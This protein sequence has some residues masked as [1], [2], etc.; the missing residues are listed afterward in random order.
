M[1]APLFARLKKAPQSRTVRFVRAELDGV[2]ACRQEQAAQFLLRF[3]LPLL[4]RL[5][6][7][8]VP[9]V[10]FHHFTGFRVLQDEI[11]QGRQFLLE[12]IHDVHGDDVVT[13]VNLPKGRE[14]G[15]SQGFGKNGAAT[16]MRGDVRPCRTSLAQK[17]GYDDD[18]GA[19]RGHADEEF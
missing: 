13:A 8:F 15:L 1:S 3:D 16:Q 10:D 2:D 6:F 19:M 18:D 17:V 7:P 4:K 12:A 9:G 14:G 11:T 5:P